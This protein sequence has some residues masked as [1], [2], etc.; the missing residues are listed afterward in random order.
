MEIW[1]SLKLLNMPVAKIAKNFK[2]PILKGEIDYD[3][4]NVPC[5]VTQKEWD[6]LKNDVQ[7][8]SMALHML[9]PNGLDKMTVG[10]CAFRDYKDFIGEKTFKRLFPVLTI[11]EDAKIRLAYRGGF[12][13]CNPENQDIEHGEG[14]VL[15]VNSLYPM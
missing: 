3:R 10:A 6:Y 5:E 7:I 2:L 8:M 11:E 9:I 13:Y 4:H 14:I 1:D 15:D 12:T